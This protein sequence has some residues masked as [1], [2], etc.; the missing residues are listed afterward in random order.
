MSNRR[1]LPVGGVGPV[2]DEDEI[3]AVA[4]ALR[5]GIDVG[6][7][8]EEFERRGADLLG[9]QHAVMVNSGTSAL[10]LAVDLLDCEPGDEV[11]TSALTFSS[12]IAPLA[13]AGIVSVLVDVHPDTFQIDVERIEEMVGPRTKAILAPNLIGNC[14]DW[15]RIRAIAD[16]HDLLVIEDT[17]D[18]LGSSL[19][20]T[21]TGARADIVCTSFARGH[22]I[23]AA[24]QGGMIAMDNPEWWDKSLVR[25][26]WGRRSETYLFGSRHSLKDRFGAL[27]D[28]TPYDLVFLFEDLGYNFSPS[29]AMA[30][31]AL[32]Q[33]D[34]LDGFNQRRTANF[35]RI[36]DVLAGH[37]D[38][39]TRPRTTDGVESTWMMYPLVLADGIER[40]PVQ[41]F[42]RVHDVPTR[43]VWSGNILRQPGFTNI[44]HRVAAD[45]LPN[46]D[47][48]MDH[49]MSLPTYHWMPSDDVGRV[50]S[51]VEEWVTSLGG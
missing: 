42:F 17:C 30:A 47:R 41:E 28:G 24:G 15:D 23:T 18:V 25:R 38:L 37:D 32:V 6:P 1:A 34:K 51:A 11:I 50:I 44:P 43:M 14:P 33:L 7:R 4:E 19:R 10:Q 40:T 46:A 2:P 12:D 5:S 35:Q 16:A 13:R 45:G 39:V 27:A 22:S 31:Y 20:G 36:D 29:E 21:P 8:V 26:R 3:E 9:K 49:G 48:V